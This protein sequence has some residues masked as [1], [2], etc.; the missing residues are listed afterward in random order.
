MPSKGDNGMEI[1]NVARALKVI[2]SL[3]GCSYKKAW[4]QYTHPAIT[5]KFTFADVLE[6]LK[7]AEQ[8][9]QI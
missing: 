7:E 2:S 1:E 8:V 5:E 4:D 3:F 9:E 6:Y